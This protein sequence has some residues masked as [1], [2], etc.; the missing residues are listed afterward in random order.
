MRQPSPSSRI[1]PGGHL[2]NRERI[3]NGFFTKLIVAEAERRG[4]F[5]P[6]SDAER[7]ASWRAMLA[8][9]P[10]GGEV[11]VFGYGSLM[12]NPAFHYTLRRKGLVRGYHRRHCMWSGFGRGS[13]EFKG[14]MLGLDRGGSCHGVAFRIAPEEVEEEIDIIWKREMI[15]GAY[16]PRWLKVLTAEG[17]VRAIAFTINRGYERYAGRLPDDIIVAHVATAE[18][19]L[20]TCHEYLVNTVAQLDELGIRDG[21]M[22]DLLR[23]VEDYRENGGMNR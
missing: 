13:D 6:M 1:A 8:E 20:G 16:R 4:Y 7:E 12:W 9:G 11:W 5:R 2:I 19:K 21:A 23:Q 17:P 3:K 22:H 18:G 15:G 10:P 14:L